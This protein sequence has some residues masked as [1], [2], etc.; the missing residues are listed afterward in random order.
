M[1]NYS[2]ALY[3]GLE[4]LLNELK[5]DFGGG[6]SFEK[7]YIMAWLIANFSLKTTVDIGVYRG[8]SLFPQAFAHKQ[9]TGGTVYGIDPWDNE[10]ARQID[11][12]EQLKEIDAFLDTTDLSVIYQ[13]VNRFNIAERLAG[14]CVLVREKSED[15]VVQFTG[16]GIMFDLIHIDGNHD[17]EIVLKDVASYLPLL[18]EK[19]F[20]ILDD[21]SWDSVRPAYDAISAKYS[22]LYKKTDLLNDYAIFW[23]NSN[24]SE[25]AELKS[26]IKDIANIFEL[27]DIKDLR[28]Y[29]EEAQKRISHLEGYIQSLAEERTAIV[30]QIGLIEKENALI[31]ERLVYLTGVEQQL[32][33]QR[34]V[35]A[36]LQSYI[37]EIKRGKAYAVSLIMQKVYS[38][39]V[40]RNSWLDRI[41]RKP[42]NRS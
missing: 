42:A 29:L 26:T 3:S 16:K 4:K 33:V 27:Q 19:G 24:E 21:I 28:I 13:E 38:K 41:I 23:R 25:K 34:R 5:V 18:S 9:Y 39:V 36:D 35:S 31:K 12:K 32:H 2:S 37:D 40:P 17:T 7:A 8:R 14:N 10:L 30:T 6:C 11:N 15:A 22:L 20:V 1:E